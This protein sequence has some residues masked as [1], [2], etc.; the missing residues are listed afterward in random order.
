LDELGATDQQ[1]ILD[2]HAELS[3]EAKDSSL[4]PKDRDT[5]ESL[6]REAKLSI[7][8]TN[9]N[10]NTY[11]EKAKVPVEDDEEDHQN[12]NPEQ[13]TSKDEQDVNDILS[14]VQ[15]SIKLSKTITGSDSSSVH[16]VDRD[17]PPPYEEVTD[18]DTGLMA[19]F[20][21]LQSL[22]LPPPPTTVPTD[23]LGL[24]LTP[25]GTPLK[26]GEKPP[27]QKKVDDMIDDIEHWCCKLRFL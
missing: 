12:I 22:S 21:A 6:L 8:Q 19:R 5:I 15:E 26:K 25:Q 17:D 16:N 27:V 23:D 11:T 4:E 13:F 10:N 24:P 18:D 14:Q 7:N 20:A 1:W 9:S 3:S 2:S